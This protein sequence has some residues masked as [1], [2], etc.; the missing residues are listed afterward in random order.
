MASV[1]R[2]SI[3]PVPFLKGHPS[4]RLGTG[5]TYNPLDKTTGR[6]RACN[7]SISHKPTLTCSETRHSANYAR[8]LVRNR[9]WWKT[10]KLTVLQ[11]V[12]GQTIP[13]CIKCGCTELSILEINHIDGAKGRTKEHGS[14]LWLPIW[15]GKRGT[16]DLDVR[17]RVCNWLYEIEVRKPEVASRFTVVWRS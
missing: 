8:L 5:W 16:D 2:R 13:R 17:C 14:G 9:S 11:K 4:P 3:S 15:S 7:L 1:T 10:T 6:C 12:S